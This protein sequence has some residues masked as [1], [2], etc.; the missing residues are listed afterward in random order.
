MIRAVLCMIRA[1]VTENN[2]FNFTV[3]AFEDLSLYTDGGIFSLTESHPI[4]SLSTKDDEE[5]GT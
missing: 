1:H 3:T 2:L 4:S 5:P